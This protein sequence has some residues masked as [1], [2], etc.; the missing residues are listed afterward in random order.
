M[1]NN[2]KISQV[3]EKD[4]D[5]VVPR[6][7]FCDMP[8]E[9]QEVVVGAAREACKKHHDGELKYYKTKYKH[10]QYKN[11]PRANREMGTNRPVTINN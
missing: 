3:K 10:D 9:L 4:F 2:A 11:E 1:A 6:E 5:D 8:E 7:G